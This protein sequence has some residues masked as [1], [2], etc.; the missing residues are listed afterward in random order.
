M[1]IMKEKKQISEDKALL[2]NKFYLLDNNLM[3]GVKNLTQKHPTYHRLNFIIKNMGKDNGFKLSF[4]KRLRHDYEKWV[5]S[6]QE[7]NEE[8]DLFKLSGF[9][10]W[11]Y[12]DIQR[13]RNK[14]KLNKKNKAVS[15]GESKYGQS[16][17]DTNTGESPMSSTDT[18]TSLKNEYIE[19]KPMANEEL[20]KILYLIEYNNNKLKNII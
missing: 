16:K 6:T 15:D 20:K 9:K 10:S 13:E 17:Y 12:D 11:L 3:R 1:N 4:M 8:T 5:N 7:N 19:N 14:N 18:H 2:N